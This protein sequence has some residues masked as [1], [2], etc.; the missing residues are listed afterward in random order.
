MLPLSF[1]KQLTNLRRCNRP[2]SNHQ[3]TILFILEKI[4]AMFR[5]IYS[6]T[7]FAIVFSVVKCVHCKLRNCKVHKRNIKGKCN[8]INWSKIE[9]IVCTINQILK[10]IIGL[11]W[12]SKKN[13]YWIDSI[14]LM[15]APESLKVNILWKARTKDLRWNNH[16]MTF[17]NRDW[18]I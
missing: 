2:K 3:K 10:K 1:N 5:K 16:I 9:W 18:L 6:R 4:K 17:P 13:C 8:V 7:I 15:Y 12:F 11:N 14:N